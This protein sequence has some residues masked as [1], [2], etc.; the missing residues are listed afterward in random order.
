MLYASDFVGEG[1]PY[2]TYII[3]VKLVNKNRYG[4]VRRSLCF[5]L[6]AEDMISG[7]VV[8]P[9]V[10]RAPGAPKRHFVSAYWSL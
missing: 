2:S 4:T 7:S 8:V 3:C 10:F 1:G 5:D 9:I 6:G